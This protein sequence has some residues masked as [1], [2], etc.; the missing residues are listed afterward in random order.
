MQDGIIQTLKKP[1]L[2]D[3]QRIDGFFELLPEIQFLEFIDQLRLARA[4]NENGQEMLESYL[5]YL[6]KP[7]A[8]FNERYLKEAFDEFNKV[9]LRFNDFLETNFFIES[10]VYMLHPTMRVSDRNHYKE[11]SDELEE[12]CVVVAK[13]YKKFTN[14]LA[15]I[16]PSSVSR[17]DYDKGVMTYRNELPY[18]PS[19]ERVVNMLDILWEYGCKKTKNATGLQLPA[20]AVQMEMADSAS[21]VNSKIRSK[22]RRLIKDT[23]DYIRKERKFPVEITVSD[24]IVYLFRD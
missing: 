2:T 7:T 17:V 9:F 21:D 5:G 22:L 10:K 20:L 3:E 12:R 6:N 8:H 13:Q 11:K 18:S 4:F 23:D 19:S 1:L 24:G 16:Q 14:I 15:S